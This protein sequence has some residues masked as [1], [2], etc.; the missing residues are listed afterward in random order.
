MS[1]P[2]LKPVR[3]V[4]YRILSWKMHDSRETA[5]V[6][7]AAIATTLLLLLNAMLIFMTINAALDREILPAAKRSSLFG[8]VAIILI[9]SYFAMNSAWVAN[10]R[11]N[12]LEA[13]FKASGRMLRTLFWC[14]IVLSIGAPFVFAVI[15]RSWHV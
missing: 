10:G 15:W 6:L 2:V 4:F 13:E 11:W 1:D 8:P 7:V 12:R 5:P 3:Y 14:Y 9:A